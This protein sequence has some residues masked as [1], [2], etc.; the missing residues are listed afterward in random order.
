MA[1][2][3]NTWV[4]SKEQ[5]FISHV[6]RGWKIQGTVGGYLAEAWPLFI[7]WCLECCTLWRNRICSSHEEPLKSQKGERKLASYSLP[8]PVPP[9]RWSPFKLPSLDA[10]A[11]AVKFYPWFCRE[12][13]PKPGLL[14]FRFYLVWMVNILLHLSQ[15]TNALISDGTHF[16]IMWTC[17]H[18][19]A[20]SKQIFSVI[21]WEIL[22]GTICYFRL[23][24]ILAKTRGSLHEKDLIALYVWSLVPSW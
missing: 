10:I 3:Q 23:F 18:L 20:S 13:T 22:P 21:E 2:L 16:T 9:I 12:Q 17:V 4:V 14:A 15:W 7:K 5:K 11:G 8:T 24:H 1:V 6:S 19:E